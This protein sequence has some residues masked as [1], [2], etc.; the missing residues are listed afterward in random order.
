M[1]TNLASFADVSAPRDVLLNLVAALMGFLIS[2]FWRVAR[3]RL[4]FRGLRGFWGVYAGKCGV[5]V[6]GRLEAQ[7]LLPSSG[8]VQMLDDVIIEGRHEEAA[9]R[10]AAYLVQQENSG[11][12]GVADL[13]AYAYII[14][15]LD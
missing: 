14:A 11:L 10:L 3:L 6:F 5:V 9:A 1:V 4:S 7:L 13:E 8:L 12:I 15:R 2:Q